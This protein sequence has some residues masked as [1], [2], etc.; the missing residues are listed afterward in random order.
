MLEDKNEQEVAGQ[1]NKR[2]KQRNRYVVVQP[3]CIFTK[4]PARAYFPPGQRNI[5]F[6]RIFIIGNGISGITTAR[7]VRKLSGH[8]ITV[9]SDESP[10]FFSRTALMYVYM[11]HLRARDT[12]PYEPWFWEKNNIELVQDR[13]QSID[14]QNKILHLS[15]GAQKE[16]DRLVL[17]TGS[18]PNRFNWPGQELEGVQGLYHWQDLEN[19]ERLS[20]NIRRA[21]IVGGG[22]IGVEMAEMFHSRGI[23]VTFLVREHRYWSSVLPPEESQMVERHLQEHHIDLRLGEEL[24]AILPDASGKKCA[25]IRTKNGEELPCEFVGLTA[26]VSPNIQWLKNSPLEIRRGIL[27]DGFLQTNQPDV[28]AVGDCAELRQPEPGRK[29]IEAIWYTG[30]MM[31]ET[32]AHTLCGRPTAYHPGIWFNSAKFFD[33]EYQ[34]YG[35]V[36][37]DLPDDQDTVYWEHPQGRKSIRINYNKANGAVRGFNL[38]GIRYRQEVCERWIMQQARVEEVLPRLGLANF[39]PEFST[40]HEPELRAQYERQSGITVGPVRRRGLAG[41]ITYLQK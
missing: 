34:V 20:A 35:D 8:S 30:R 40:E 26:G 14:F 17:A 28:Y 27:V 39:D 33:I 25:G 31:G 22:L 23:P 9:I 1:T 11:G 13:V 29:A 18:V 4:N 5:R 38:M 21:V 37:A 15:S 10:Y 24:E 7:F 3:C 6:M 2:E 16:Y 19:M 32:L 41:V 12:Q 36:R